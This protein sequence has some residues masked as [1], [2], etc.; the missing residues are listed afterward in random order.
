MTQVSNK[1][2]SK[3][4]QMPVKRPG[5]NGFKY[6]QKYGLVVVCNDEAHQQSLFKRLTKLSLKVKVVCV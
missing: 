1:R 3:G 6:R 4:V 2:A 5:E